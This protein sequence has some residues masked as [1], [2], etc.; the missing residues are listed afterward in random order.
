MTLFVNKGSKFIEEHF[1]A[2]P[3]P[4]NYYHTDTSS[5]TTDTRPPTME[6]RPHCIYPASLSDKVPDKPNRV[7]NEAG[8]SARKMDRVPTQPVSD[9]LF[10]PINSS[11][12]LPGYHVDTC[13][14]QFTLSKELLDFGLGGFSGCLS[15]FRI[16]MRVIG[17]SL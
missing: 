16:K 11:G 7:P 6:H 8:Q 4:P 5:I 17:T 9:S 2:T 10:N 13:T 1:Y 15:N 3:S 14:F 12:T